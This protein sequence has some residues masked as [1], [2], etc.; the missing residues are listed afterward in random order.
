MSFVAAYGRRSSAGVRSIP[1]T[2]GAGLFLAEPG[3]VLTAGRIEL[4]GSFIYLHHAGQVRRLLGDF[5][6]CKLRVAGYAGGNR[7]AGFAREVGRRGLAVHHPRLSV[8]GGRQVL[9]RHVLAEVIGGFRVGD[10]RDLHFG[11]LLRCEYRGLQQLRKSLVIVVFGIPEA[12]HD[13]R[14]D[15]Q[16][17]SVWSSP[18]MMMPLLASPVLSTS[19][20]T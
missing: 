2:P 12:D 18:L 17:L 10:L 16:R 11:L 7:L 3:Y 13:L 4:V 15:G 14:A 8:F 19:E 1:G 6:V 5:L 9:H 20:I